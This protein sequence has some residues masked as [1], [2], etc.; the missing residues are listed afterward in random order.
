MAPEAAETEPAWADGL[1]AEQRLAASHMGTNARLL[2]GPG[3]GKTYTLKARVAFLVVD[4]EIEPDAVVALT[5]TRAAA[6]ELRSRV[7]KALEGEIA[8]RPRIM[9]LH[10]FALRTLMKNAELL[11]AL[12]RPLRIADDWEERNIV[13]EDL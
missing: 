12:P 10:A 5:F 1:L 6:G 3:T 4:Q 11:D 7:E 2:A 13:Q 9:T 8:G